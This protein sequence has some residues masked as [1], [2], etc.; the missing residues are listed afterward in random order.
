M[1]QTKRSQLWV[2][3]GLSIRLIL[4]R[5][6]QVWSYNTVIARRAGGRVLRIL[7]ILENIL[8]STQRISNYIVQFF[9]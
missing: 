6:T 3:D 5:K 2:N 9:I 7:S 4:E 1:E 8:M